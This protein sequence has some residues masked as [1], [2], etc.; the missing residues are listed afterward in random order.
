MQADR[1]SFKRLDV[2]LNIFTGGPILSFCEDFLVLDG[3]RLIHYANV[4]T[5]F[6]DANKMCYSLAYMPTHSVCKHSVSSTLL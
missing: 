4:A 1:I 6:D 3:E 2:F 5:V